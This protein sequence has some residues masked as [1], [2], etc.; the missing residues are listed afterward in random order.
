V[1]KG[2]GSELSLEKGTTISKLPMSRQADVHA[3]HTV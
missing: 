3:L 1:S 2:V